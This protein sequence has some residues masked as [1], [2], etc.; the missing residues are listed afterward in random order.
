MSR[1]ATARSSAANLQARREMLVARAGLERVAIRD[2]T[3]DL[4]IASE[5][6]ARIAVTGLSLLRRYW[7][8]AGLLLAG[9]LSRRARPF[10]RMARTGLAVWQA[11]RLLRR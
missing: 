9:G 3:R 11:V 1:H 8:P 7:L 6:V 4:Q 2:A 5:R 10:L